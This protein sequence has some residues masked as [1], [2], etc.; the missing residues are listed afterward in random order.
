MKKK[1][2]I[3]IIIILLLIITSFTIYNINIGKSKKESKAKDNSTGVKNI[4]FSS[5]EVKNIKLDGNDISIKSKGVYKLTG[6]LEN[7]NINIDSNGEVKLII[8]NVDISTKGEPCINIT[9][10]DLVYI[11]VVGDNK[12]ICDTTT[13][14]NGA[15]NSKGDLLLSGDGTLNIESNIDGIVT[16]DDLQIDSGTIVINSEDDGLVGRDSIEINN[17]EITINSSGDGLKTTNQEKGSLKISGGNIDIT[18]KLDGIQVINSINIEDGNIKITTGNGSSVKSTSEKWMNNETTDSIKGIKS[19]TD[20]NISGGTI[21]IN[22]EDDSIHSNGNITINGS[23][24][25]IF[26]GD[27]GIHADGNVNISSDMKINES[28]EG[29]EGANITI[30]GGDISV[31]STDDG[32]NAAGGDG[33]SQGRRGANKG[34]SDGKTYVLTINDGKV[35]VNAQ[36]DGLDSNG[37]IYIK[38]GEIYVDGPTNSGNGAIDFG[39]G[40][41]YEFEISGG[42][43]VAVGSSGMAVSPTSGTKQTSV[44]INLEDTYE[45][46]IEFS[47]IKYEPNKSYNSILISSAKLSKDKEYTLKIGNKEI[48]TLKLTD[49]VT[50]S[51]NSSRG[52]FTGGGRMKGDRM[53]P[54]MEPGM[55]PIN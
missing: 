41:N 25:T 23:N 38:G 6:S 42:T 8:D 18:S 14:L 54:D 36:G 49:T 22:S 31:K 45:D 20:I 11:Q 21:N 17:G 30:N 28:Y 5:Y 33:S 4:D 29:I 51:G 53:K 2:Y 13:D 10:S 35:Y 3:V 47:D 44:L 24:I 52:G 32:F 19:D 27:D 55:E 46:S 1:I 48:Q 15:I 40:G 12:L 16:K 37:N 39:D 7:K 34:Y 9:S 43:L 26:S 50:T